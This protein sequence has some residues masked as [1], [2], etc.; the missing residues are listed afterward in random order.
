MKQLTKPDLK[1]MNDPYK[2]HWCSRART[3]EV[4]ENEFKGKFG[5][6]MA[7]WDLTQE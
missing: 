5:E 4:I 1:E 3:P 7:I 2:P 6:K